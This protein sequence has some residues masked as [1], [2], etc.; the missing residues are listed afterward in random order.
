MIFYTNSLCCISRIEYAVS[1]SVSVGVVPSG[2][3]ATVIEHTI[4]RQSYLKIH[5]F[6]SFVAVV[7]RNLYEYVLGK[8]LKSAMLKHTFN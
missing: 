8:R 1:L 6:T 4:N 7:I 2:T 5:S 3:A